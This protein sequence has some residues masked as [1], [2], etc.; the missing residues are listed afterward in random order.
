MSLTDESIAVIEEIHDNRPPF[1][2]VQPGFTIGGLTSHSERLALIKVL[3]GDDNIWDGLTGG[4]DRM[5][6]YAPNLSDYPRNHAKVEKDMTLY[7]KYIQKM[8][9]TLIHIKYRAVRTK[10]NEQSQYSRHKNELHSDY[11]VDVTT[12]P[13]RQQPISMIVALDGF[14][15]I[16]LPTKMS[17]RKELIYTAVSPGQMIFFTNDC[18]HSGGKNSTPNTLICL[19]AYMVSQPSDIPTNSVVKYAWSDTT[20]EDAVIL[21]SWT[22]V[23]QKLDESSIVC[24]HDEHQQLK[25]RQKQEESLYYTTFKKS[26]HNVCQ[27]VC[28][29][30]N[31]GLK[32]NNVICYSNSIFQIIASC[33]QFKKYLPTPPSE[34]HKHFRLYYEFSYV[35]SSMFSAEGDDAVDSKNYMDVFMTTCPQFNGNQST[36]CIVVS[37]SK[38]SYIH[39]FLLLIYFLFGNPS[40]DAH[41]Y[42]MVLRNCLLHELQP[43]SVCSSVTASGQPYEEKLHKAM[44]SFWEQFSTGI[45]KQTIICRTCSNVTKKHEQFSELMIHFHSSQIM[46]HESSCTLKSILS[47]NRSGQSDIE[48]YH[49]VHCESLMVAK[50][51]EE[52]TVYPELL[53]I[54]LCQKMSEDDTHVNNIINTAVEFPLED[55]CLSTISNLQQKSLVLYCTTLLGL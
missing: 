40:E 6:E 14:N 12:R 44:I 51:H 49:C 11:T 8:Y 47:Y 19:F 53:L 31:A 21:D 3:N 23:K 4:R 17:S 25:I 52:I 33:N 42:I 48:D 46:K 35:I 7:V 30:R 13:T 55:F 43:W 38:F 15:F 54:V 39:V 41:E 10:P 28:D 27:I 16:Y 45:V 2:L 22:S 29:G 20:S 18:L 26:R 37:T 24:H 5:R 50:K 32:N 1:S 36:Y 34:E 9:P